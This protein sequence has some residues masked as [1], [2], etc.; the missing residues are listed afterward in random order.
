MGTWIKKLLDY[1]RGDKVEKEINIAIAHVDKALPYIMIAAEIVAALSPSN[2]PTE[3]LV[4]VNSK[5]PRLF[6][7]SILTIDEL[8]TYML[9][10]ASALLENNFPGLSTT[11]AILATQLAYTKAKASGTNPKIIEPPKGVLVINAKPP[12][13]SFLEI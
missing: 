1:F 7:G 6:D 3:I 5:F 8:K 2:I 10:I 13:K 11:N 9:G 4:V 12:K